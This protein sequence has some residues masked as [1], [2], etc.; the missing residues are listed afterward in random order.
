[1][2]YDLHLTAELEVDRLRTVLADSFGLPPANVN[3]A[4]ADERDDHHWEAAVACAYERTLG[5]LTWYLEVVSGDELPASPSE[6]Q[7]ATTLAEGLGQAVVF[8]ADTLPPS[9]HWLAAPGGL[10]TRA[11]IYEVDEAGEDGFTRFVIDAV[12]HKVTGLPQLRVQRQPE[13]IREHRVPTPVSDRFTAWLADRSET[14]ASHLGSAE[15]YA[16]TRLSAWEALT[17]RMAWNWPPDG[18]YPTEYYQ[19]DLETRDDLDHVPDQVD[20]DV[21]E[22]F[23]EALAEVDRAFRDA[24]VDDEAPGVASAQAALRGWWWRRRPEPLPWGPVTAVR[25]VSAAGGKV[26]PE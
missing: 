6:Q 20:R 25:F 3:V 26:C 10:L 17:V 4:A 22:R 24:T 21:A 7:L 23:A 11:R 18:W 16:R 15:W 14:G 5:D 19:Q 8:S 12:G 9:A 13:V 2:I 1:M